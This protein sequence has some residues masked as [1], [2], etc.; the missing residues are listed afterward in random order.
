MVKRLLLLNGLAVLCAVVHHAVGWDVT[1]MFFWTDRYLPVTVPNLDQ[2][3]GLRYIF[4]RFI[5]QFTL[6]GLPAFLIV[7]GYFI[8]VA[9]GSRLS[10]LSWKMV[11]QR[12]KTL[13]I[14]Y[15]IWSFVL[16]AFNLVQGVRYSGVDI[17]YTLLT[18]SIAPP[19]YYVPL[20]IQ[21]YLL[22]PFMVHLARNHWKL[23]LGFAAFIQ[24]PVTYAHYAL[25]L[26]LDQGAWEPVLAVLRDWHLLGYA[27]WFVLGM[28]IG[29]HLE[30]FKG[31]LQRA[32]PVLLAGLVLTF[33]ASLAEWVLLERASAEIW[34]SSQIAILAKLFVLFVLLAFFAFNRLSYPTPAQ[35][36]QLGAKS[37]GI[38]LIHSLFLE[39]TARG[40]YHVAPWLLAYQLPFL[41]L[42]V[43]AGVAFPL[44][45]MWGVNRVSVLRP[46]YGY[47]FG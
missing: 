42:L 38:Y 16:I 13:V 34:L 27:V 43:A 39:L 33:I 25:V 47:L 21:L 11:F 32:R 14:P 23:L 12:V 37:F 41:A 28:V 29:F 24:L 44:A 4:L 22:A 31:F 8:A 36:A 7:S 3:W 15:L 46:Y 18:G 35:L 9:T 20:L 1:A 5:D 17:A 2:M 6:P 30:A 40:V 26:K 10:G 19:Y 45:L